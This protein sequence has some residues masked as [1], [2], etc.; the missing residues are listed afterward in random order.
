MKSSE[1]MRTI[2]QQVERLPE[3]RGGR[4]ITQAIESIS[5]MV[6]QL[7]AAHRQQTR[8]TEQA[9]SAASRSKRLHAARTH[10]SGAHHSRRAH[11]QSPSKFSGPRPVGILRCTGAMICSGRDNRRRLKGAT[12]VR[13]SRKRPSGRLDKAQVERRFTALAEIDAFFSQ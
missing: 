8:G 13:S 11:A 4:Q 12:I 1:K 3:R 10:R 2:S 9:L 5:H 7:N 6:N